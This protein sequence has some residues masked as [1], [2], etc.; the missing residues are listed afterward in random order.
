MKSDLRG[1][2]L[3]YQLIHAATWNRHPHL[4]NTCHVYPGQAWLR[5]VCL[6]V[7]M[8][9]CVCV[10]ARVCCQVCYCGARWV[11]CCCAAC[12]PQINALN[13]TLSCS[14]CPL[15]LLTRPGWDRVEGFERVFVSPPVR[16]RGGASHY[17]W[18]AKGGHGH[19]GL[20][21]ESVFFWH[22][23]QNWLFFFFFFF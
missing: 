1:F 22:N 3:I 14:E 5:R 2:K 7:R 17:E 9:V 12:G 4:P 13:E 20:K 21:P 16:G 19:K 11:L 6:C 15:C 10:C 8:C 23:M 18:K